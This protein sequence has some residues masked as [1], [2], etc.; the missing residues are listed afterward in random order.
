MPQSKE[1]HK[2][3]MRKRRKGSQDKGSQ[4]EGSQSVKLPQVVGN[5]GEADDAVNK[6]DLFVEAV[7]KIEPVILSDGQAWYPGNNG[8]HPK[9]CACKRHRDRTGLTNEQYCEGVLI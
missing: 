1:V 6:Y 2:E 7:E 8:Y 4:S 5:G 9:S 3:Y